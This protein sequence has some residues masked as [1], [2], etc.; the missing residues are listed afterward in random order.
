MVSSNEGDV[1]DLHGR[2]GYQPDVAGLARSHVVSARERLGLSPAE[3]AEV[4]KP[5][6]P[7][8]PLTGGLIEIWET[9]AVPP[10]DVL[11]AI[12]V[13]TRSTPL[14]ASDASAD[15]LVNQLLGRRFAD[16]AAVF[17][18]RAELNSRLP[19]HDLFA[20]AHTIDVAGMSLNLLCQQYP[21]DSLRQQLEEGATLRC[22][23]LAPGG[24]AIADREREENYPQGHLSALTEM[25]IRILTDRVGKRVGADA[26]ARLQL[27]SYDEIPR[28]NLLLVD[29]RVA[30]VQPY[31]PFHRG[32]ESPTLLLRRQTS[33]PG[34]FAIFAQLFDELWERSTA[35]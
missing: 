25:N 12:G 32:V 9:T 13:L 2:T 30:V 28:F 14:S 15:D 5:L 4:L 6:L 3:F 35:L 22:L 8:H 19:P 20:G 1:L 21:E 34:L 29:H 16:V 33:T 18:T 11:V 26:R 31:L 24:Q 10:G 27:A 23:F 17:T 7:N